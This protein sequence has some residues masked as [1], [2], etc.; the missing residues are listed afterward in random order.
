M[1]QKLSSL[2]INVTETRRFMETKQNVYEMILLA[3]NNNNKLIKL[4][5]WIIGRPNADFIV[6]SRCCF[7]GSQHNGIPSLTDAVDVA[8]SGPLDSVD[9][10]L[11]VAARLETAVVGVL[12][13]RALTRQ[14]VVHGAPAR[15]THTYLVKAETPS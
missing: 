9:R 6:N 2:Q 15:Y 10:L 13:Q 3:N 5:R 4:S 8:Q 7:Q 12:H 1:T 11:E 14:V